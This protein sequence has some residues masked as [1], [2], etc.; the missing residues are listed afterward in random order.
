MRLPV[1]SD[2]ADVTL[3]AS[4]WRVTGERSPSPTRSWRRCGYRDARPAHAGHA[5]AARRDVRDACRQPLAGA[6]D[7][8]R[9]DLL[10]LPRAEPILVSDASALTLPVATGTAVGG[11]AAVGGV[12]TEIAHRRSGARGPARC[13]RSLGWLL[14]RRRRRLLPSRPDL[15]DVPLVVEGLVKTYSDGHR[16]VDDVSWRAE[17]GQVV[18][19]LGPNGAGKTTTMRMVMGLIAS[20]RR[21]GARAR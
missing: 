12:D 11:A 7:E 3:F 5:V 2:T 6:A 8:H 18:G 15:A 20:G 9:V 19:L 17:K 14:R 21:H 4:V 1:T 10:Q 13:S 16:A